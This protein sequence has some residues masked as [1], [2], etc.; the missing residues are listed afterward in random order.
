MVYSLKAHPVV[1]DIVPGAGGK[2]VESISHGHVFSA[3]DRMF[4][5]VIMRVG[6]IYPR[7]ETLAARK[8]FVSQLSS[9]VLKSASA[10]KID[11][12]KVEAAFP[13]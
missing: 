7:S 5:Q 11:R 10:S 13:H 3:W 8:T 4:Q 12:R 6:A 1:V 2:E 9:L